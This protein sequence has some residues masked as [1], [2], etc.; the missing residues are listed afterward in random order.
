ME[1]TLKKEWKYMYLPV[2]SEYLPY[3]LLEHSD[4]ISMIN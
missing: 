4:A 3:T 2:N 1:A